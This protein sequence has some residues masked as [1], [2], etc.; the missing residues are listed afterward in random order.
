[1]KIEDYRKEI[2]SLDKEIVESL[3]KR[4]NL[5]EAIGR[6]KKEKALEIL[7][8]SREEEVLEGIKQKAS[9][10]LAKHILK[11]YGTIL[12]E[13]KARQQIIQDEMK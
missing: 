13:S 7:D 6:L 3:E 5:A 11:I 9:P 10:E 4:M 2:D 8:S 12:E 1:M